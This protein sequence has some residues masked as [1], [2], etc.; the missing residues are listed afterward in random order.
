VGAALLEVRGLSLRFGGIEAL[1]DV[2]IDVAEGETVA[3]VGPNGSGK[4]SLFNCVTGVYRASSGTIAI[5]GRAVGHARPHEIAALGVARTFQSVRLFGSLSVLD[6]LLVGR[7]RHL[8]KSLFGALLRRR[9]DGTVHRERCEELLDL[10]DLRPWRA[11]R[12]DECPYGVQKR[13][14][15]A[16]ALA[17][18]PRLILLDEPAS[19][20]DAEE[21]DR[22]SRAIDA[23]RRKSGAA[24]LLIEHDL[25]FA[26]SLAGR[27]IAFDRGRTLVEGPP[28][29]VQRH[30]AVVRDWLGGA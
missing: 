11:H 2:S 6:N 13:V 26:A 28:A 22:A 15:L 20:L 5:A 14:G 4:T 29:D 16:R 30:P 19:G 21:K 18:E 17:A 25:P 3:L 24:V 23:A 8:R 27:M 7:H 9:G 10:L 1:G 12:A